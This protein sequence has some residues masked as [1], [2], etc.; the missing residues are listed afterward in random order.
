MGEKLGQDFPNI[1]TQKTHCGSI[2]LDF[3]HRLIHIPKKGVKILVGHRKGKR[4]GK[5]EIS[6]V[7]VMAKVSTPI[8]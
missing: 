1:L 4:R 8:R 6:K 7:L 3:H 5:M 2:P